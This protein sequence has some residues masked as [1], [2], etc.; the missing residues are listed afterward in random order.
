MIPLVDMHC[1]LIAGVDDGPR[2]L[3]D[4][5]AMCRI[6]LDEG[7]DAVH[8]L[9]HQNEFYPD[10]TP[11]VIRTVHAQLTER[12]RAENLPLMVYLGAEIIVVPDLDEVWSA[13]R[14]LSVADRGQYL[15]IEMPHGLFV[16][17]GHTIWRL[18]QLGLR[19]ILAHPEQTPELLHS[20]ELLA[21]WVDQGLLTQVSSA[22]VLRMQ[23]A[24]GQKALRNWFRR[25]LVH[26]LGSDGHSP[27]RRPPHLAAAAHTVVEWVGSAAADR[28][29]GG[30]GLAILQGLPLRVAPPPKSSAFSW[31][32]R[33]WR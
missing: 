27:D 7:V 33:W 31:L 25:G 24:A 4:A 26:T 11:E 21:T 3:D 15:F 19:P 20:P 22:N 1:H 12:L 9:A 5:V 18:T 16:D 8:G 28:I 13:G 32:P 2:T 14:L 23:S 29:L 6:L 17:L 10:V 30:N